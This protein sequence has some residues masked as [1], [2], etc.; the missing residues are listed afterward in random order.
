[1]VE[2]KNQMANVWSTQLKLCPEIDTWTL[3]VCLFVCLPVVCLPVVCLFVY[4]SKGLFGG[5][6]NHSFLVQLQLLLLSSFVVHANKFEVLLLLLRHTHTQKNHDQCQT[7]KVLRLTSAKLQREYHHHHHHH[8]ATMPAHNHHLLS[9]QRNTTQPSQTNK[10]TN[11][12][13][14]QVGGVNILV[15]LNLFLEG[16]MK[17]DWIAW[18]ASLS[19]RTRR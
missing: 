8:G 13:I 18:K 12:W 3:N 14:S 16:A 1:M 5:G 10:Q 6:I 9:T 19:F 15:I 11:R 7:R 2:A 4:P 17:L